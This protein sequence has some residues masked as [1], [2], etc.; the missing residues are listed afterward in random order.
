MEALQCFIKYGCMFYCSVCAHWLSGVH[1]IRVFVLTGLMYV[2]EMDNYCI[3]IVVHPQ[4]VQEKL[5]N[6]VM[7]KKGSTRFSWFSG[8]GR[9]QGNG[10][11]DK[12]VSPL[13]SSC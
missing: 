11:L 4:L 9:S 13:S 5:V 7:P 2:L 10:S 12:K 8:W 6:N 3:V 1:L